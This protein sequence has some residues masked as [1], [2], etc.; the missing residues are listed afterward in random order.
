MAVIHHFYLNDQE[1]RTADP[2]GT[3]VLDFVRRHAKLTGTKEGWCAATRVTFL[4]F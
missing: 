3:L 4:I 1:I 2:A